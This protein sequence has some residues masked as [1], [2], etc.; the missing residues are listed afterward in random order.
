MPQ[1]NIAVE[2]FLYEMK[3]ML[4]FEVVFCQ[5]LNSRLNH[6]VQIEQFPFLK[7]ILILTFFPSTIFLGTD[8]GQCYGVS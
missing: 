5:L 7:Q 8:K 2:F 4:F 1:W 3:F 6:K